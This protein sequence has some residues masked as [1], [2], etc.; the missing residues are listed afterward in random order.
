MRVLATTKVTRQNQTT[1][2]KRVRRELKIKEDDVLVWFISDEG[3]IV[4]KKA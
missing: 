3:E 4:V 2:P 1:I